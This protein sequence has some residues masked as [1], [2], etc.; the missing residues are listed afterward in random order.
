MKLAP[1]VLV[2]RDATRI[3]PQLCVER[4]RFRFVA[5]DGVHVLEAC[6]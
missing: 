5:L 3:L 6:S 2:G 1:T 4:A